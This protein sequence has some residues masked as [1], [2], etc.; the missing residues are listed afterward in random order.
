M[1]HWLYDEIKKNDND[2]SPRHAQT[3]T[4]HWALSLACEVQAEN[5]ESATKQFDSCLSL[6]K[7]NMRGAQQHLGAGEVFG[8]LFS[9]LTFALDLCSRAADGC[10]TWSLPSAVIAWYY[11]HY[12]ALRSMLAASNVLVEEYHAKS[13][14]SFGSCL[15]NRLPH[16]YNM[17][18]RWIKNGDFD[19]EL[20]DYPGTSSRL[21]IKEFDGE[22]IT[23]REMLIGYLKGTAKRELEIIKSD[24]KSKNK[25]ILDFKS[26]EAKAV[27]DKRMQ[28]VEF[29]MMHCAF[30]YRGKANYRDSVYLS[31]GSVPLHKEVDFLRSLS[32]TALFSFLLALALARVKVGKS[33][34][35]SFLSDAS[36]NLR[37]IEDCRSHASF[38]NDLSS[39]L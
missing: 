4:V 26:A 37:N 29:N 36:S 38:L 24:I 19:V 7:K 22:R 21:L 12:G 9:S 31:Y 32:T 28:G 34:T 15:R 23:A 6:L 16:P 2:W 11:A 20:P 14:R 5:G 30:R 39:Q 1:A 13:I 27:R 17:K 35:R 3:S 33:C 8:P 10:P 25:T 18:A